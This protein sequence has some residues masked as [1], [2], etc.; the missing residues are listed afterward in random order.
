MKKFINWLEG[1]LG[2]I[3]M[4]GIIL[5]LTLPGILSFPAFFS[6]LDLSKGKDIGSAIGGITA[7]VVGILTCLLVYF[8][9]KQ[10]VNFNAKQVN[11]QYY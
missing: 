5:T 3:V 7:P 10:Q 2:I 11:S 1:N 6:S 4:I 8:T 9:F